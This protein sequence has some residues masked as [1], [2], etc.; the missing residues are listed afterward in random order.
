MFIDL[1]KKILSASSASATRLVAKGAA[2]PITSLEELQSFVTTRAA[3]ISQKKLYGYLKTRM[4]TSWPKMFEDAVYKK[5][6]SVAAVNIFAASL[7]DLTIHAVAVALQNARLNDDQKTAIARQIFAYALDVN[8]MAPSAEQFDAIEAKRQ[9][10]RRLDGTDWNFGALRTENFTL[11]AAALL[12]W[13]P[14]AD[15]LKQFDAEIVENSMKFAWIEIRNEL[16]DRLAPDAVAA[17]A[18]ANTGT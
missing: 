14:I 4:G 18:E 10:D 15:E 2:K 16:C 5:S 3:Y 6:I 1:L 9:F 13:S 8:K 7:S 11:S 12:K 17:D